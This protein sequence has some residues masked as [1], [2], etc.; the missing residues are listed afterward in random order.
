MS[1]GLTLI[2]ET[3]GQYDFDQSVTVVI[4]DSKSNCDQT[5]EAF[6]NVLREKYGRSM[7]GC[8]LG[9]NILVGDDGNFT[10]FAGSLVDMARVNSGDSNIAPCPRL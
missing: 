10:D 1:A 4:T 7:D 5:V 2:G 8:V 3:M 6:Q 9:F